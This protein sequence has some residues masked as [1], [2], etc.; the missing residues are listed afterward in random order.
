M[1]CSYEPHRHSVCVLCRVVNG[2][3]ETAVVRGAAEC[4]SVCTCELGNVDGEMAANCKRSLGLYLSDVLPWH[5]LPKKRG[6]PTQ[7]VNTCEF[8][9]SGH[10]CPRSPD[11]T[12]ID[13]L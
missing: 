9:L 4:K 3:G 8:N 5:K 6:E 10:V 7:A 13:L 12:L 2:A 11:F 1:L